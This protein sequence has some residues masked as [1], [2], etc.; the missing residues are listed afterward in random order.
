ML[1]QHMRYHLK[2][3]PTLSCR[4]QLTTFSRSTCR[5]ASTSSNESTATST[6]RGCTPC[7]WVGHHGQWNK[8]CMCDA[9]FAWMLSLCAALYKGVGL[10]VSYVVCRVPQDK[11]LAHSMRHACVSK[12]PQC[13]TCISQDTEGKYL[14]VVPI[15]LNACVD[16][17]SIDACCPPDASVWHMHNLTGPQQHHSTTDVCSASQCATTVGGP[18]MTAGAAA[19][20]TFCRESCQ[21][22]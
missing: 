15:I 22:C 1:I 12:M 16:V 7:G 14:Q 10:P 21:K 8:R 11:E 17:C 4:Q 20:G 13:A 19:H 3:L 5:P 2:L 9:C 6:C 18:P